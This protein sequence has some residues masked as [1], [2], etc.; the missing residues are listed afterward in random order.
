MARIN[1]DTAK[2]L[3]ITTRLGDSFELE[4]TLKDSSGIPINLFG[5]ASD[6]TNK[7]SF[8]ML[9]QKLA[10]SGGETFASINS[11]AFADH[12]LVVTLTDDDST[13]TADTSDASYV[14][15]TAATGKVKFSISATD[16]KG[17]SPS[18]PRLVDFMYDIQYINPAEKIPLAIENSA[19]TILYGSFNFIY[20]ISYNSSTTL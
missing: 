8:K 16:M 15:S 7:Y 12:G 1:F 17:P 6:G 19:K 20:D 5:S 11:T 4:L 9:I 18:S 14:A 3:D 2:R 13:T 10:P